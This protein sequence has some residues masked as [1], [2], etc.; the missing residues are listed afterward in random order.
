LFGVF[1]EV[2]RHGGVLMCMVLN[3]G[4]LKIVL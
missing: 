4:I 2:G 1:Q 3:F